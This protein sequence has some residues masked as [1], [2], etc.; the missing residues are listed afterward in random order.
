MEEMRTSCRV[1]IRKPG[2]L[3]VDGS[4]LLKRILTEMV[5]E[6]VTGFISFRTGISVLGCCENGNDTSVSMKGASFLD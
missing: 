2:G 1:L 5:C 4:I 6:V 3:S